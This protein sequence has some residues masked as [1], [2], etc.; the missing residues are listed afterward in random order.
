MSKPPAYFS[1]R[2]YS[3]GA[4]FSGDAALDDFRFVN[5][6]F[7]N[8]GG[9]IYID[10]GE[11]PLTGFACENCTFYRATKPSLLMGKSVS[12][13]LFKNVTV[14]GE[15]IRNAEQLELSG[16]HLSVPVKF[17]P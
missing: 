11:N 13:V 6:S 5:C 1:G 8:D 15:V 7:E 3:A 10:G 14:N 12:P 16:F 2:G 4:K 17:E 9:H